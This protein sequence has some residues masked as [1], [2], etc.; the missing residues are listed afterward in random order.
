MRK[1]E[2][3]IYQ[4]ENIGTASTSLSNLDKKSPGN[5]SSE[6]KALQGSPADIYAFYA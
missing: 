4:T 6:A 5:L 3:V 2:G 1:R